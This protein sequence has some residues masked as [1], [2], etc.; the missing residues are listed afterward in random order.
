MNLFRRWLWPCSPRSDA[1]TLYKEGMACAEKKD[2]KGALLAFT[3]AIEVADAPD[4]IRAM[5]LYNRALL[6]AAEGKKDGALSDLQAVMKM[7]IPS[8]GVKLAAKRRLERLE[9][10]RESA[11]QPNRRSSS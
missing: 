4:D 5:A 11:T 3:Q 10:R 1:L 7:S 6:F 2:S 9:H 8:N